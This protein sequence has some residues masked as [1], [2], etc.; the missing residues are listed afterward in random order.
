MTVFLLIVLL[1]RTAAWAS[2]IYPGWRRKEP[3][4]E[5][6]VPNVAGAHEEDLAP[7]VYRGEFKPF[8]APESSKAE[9]AVTAYKRQLRLES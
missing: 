4:H 8:S 5:Q 2:P 7:P 9:E 6:E 3:W 1:F